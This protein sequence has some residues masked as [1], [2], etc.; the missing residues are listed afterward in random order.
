MPLHLPAPAKLN[1]VLR[2]LG[3]RPDGYHELSTLF[4]AIDL[5]D[6]LWAEPAAESTLT[7]LAGGP[8]TDVDTGPANLV[9]QAVRAFQAAA[10]A[11][12]GLRI[13][14]HKRIPMGAG[15]GGGSSDAAATL[16]LCQHLL[17]TPLPPERLREVG[18]GLGADVPFFLAGGS[19]WGRGVGDLLSPAPGVPARHFL[20][21]IP[22]F[23][24][25]T[26]AVYGMWRSELN[27]AENAASIPGV[28]NF[29]DEDSGNPG[30]YVND[31]EH[32]AE[33]V[34]PELAGLRVRV[35]R[36][37]FPSVRMTGSGS[38]LFLAFDHGDECASAAERLRFL[39]AE[40][41]ALCRTRSLGALPEPTTAPWPGET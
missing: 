38:T 10:R 22:P 36:E 13:V 39:D 2:V 33:S 23:E 30:R 34:R 41:V 3:R 19:R 21:L 4:H 8:R 27:R 5:C 37:G 40:G 1:L 17:G 9:L 7:V 14:L 24:C 32:A 18:R 28:R 12:R 26:A 11:G 25:P 20:L 15:L 6:E 31:L 35:A 29:L 16:R